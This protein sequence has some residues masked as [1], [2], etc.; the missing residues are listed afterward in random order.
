M[1]H[2][3]RVFVHPRG[4]KAFCGGRQLELWLQRL[5]NSRDDR[6][7]CAFVTDEGWSPWM[8]IEDTN[9]AMSGAGVLDE[10]ATNDLMDQLWA[11]GVRPTG[12]DLSAE[13]AALKAHIAQL[14]DTQNR[15]TAA[16]GAK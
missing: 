7:R 16:L 11:L 15:L 13:G 5:E 14:I 2:Y 3:L 10:P 8:G 1:G 9:D 4:M 6:A 12:V